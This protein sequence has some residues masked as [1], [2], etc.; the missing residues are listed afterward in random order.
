MAKWSDWI[1]AGSKSYVFETT[2]HENTDDLDGLLPVYISSETPLYF[3]HNLN[4][5]KPDDYICIILLYGNLTISYDYSSSNSEF[6]R[7]LVGTNLE[8]FNG[9]AVGFSEN[10]EDTRI[11][12]DISVR[13]NDI[14]FVPSSKINNIY[15]P[16]TLIC[17]ENT[18]LKI[19]L[20]TKP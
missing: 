13:K 2:I 3:N 5:M 4:L 19:Y 18:K 9:F 14:V 11:K 10:P 1:R 15:R 7:Q 8:D 6:Y 20:F 12:M 17:S 16:F